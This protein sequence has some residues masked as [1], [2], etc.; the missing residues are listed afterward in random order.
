MRIFLLKID[1]DAVLVLENDIL[2]WD[3]DESSPAAPPTLLR[4]WGC[5]HSVSAKFTGRFY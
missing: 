2:I 3:V 4:I 1:M 5:L